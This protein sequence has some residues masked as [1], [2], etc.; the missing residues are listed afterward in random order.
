ML[1][2]IVRLGTFHV[3]KSIATLLAPRTVC[4]FVLDRLATVN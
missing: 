2:G 1:L 3:N 4:S